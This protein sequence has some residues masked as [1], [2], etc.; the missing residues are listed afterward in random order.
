MFK[1]LYTCNIND[2][3]TYQSKQT[4]PAILG[5][6]GWVMRL[7]NGGPKDYEI[8]NVQFKQGGTILTA[9]PLALGYGTSIEFDI[10]CIAGTNDF[11]VTKEY[12]LQL[13]NCLILKVNILIMVDTLIKTFFISTTEQKN[14][15]C[16]QRKCL[17]YTY[18]RL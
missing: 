16:F 2:P 17:L 7:Y 14:R 4:D 3:N 15:Q 12:V 10:D 9:L 6:S 13:V 1:L 11:S 5:N 8:S 18:K